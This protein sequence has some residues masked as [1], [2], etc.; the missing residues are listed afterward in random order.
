MSDIMKAS[1]L[2]DGSSDFALTYEDKDGDWM[3]VGDVPWGYDAHLNSMFYSIIIRLI[4]CTCVFMSALP[5]SSSEFVL[6]ASKLKPCIT[7]PA[8]KSEKKRRIGFR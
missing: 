5:E 3:L 2:L 6:F 7:I 1:K 8:P 4:E